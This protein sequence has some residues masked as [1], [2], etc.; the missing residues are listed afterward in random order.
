MYGKLKLSQNERNAYPVD[1]TEVSAFEKCC[2][3]GSDQ[4]LL[5]RVIHNTAEGYDIY[6][7]LSET[8]H[9]SE[10]AAVQKAGG[11]FILLENKTDLVSK[12]KVDGYLLQKNGQTVARFVYHELKSGLLVIY[13]FTSTSE[14]RSRECYNAM[15][16]YLNEKIAL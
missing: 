16:P 4:V 9:Q 15:V 1:A 14:T 2:Y 12:I 11:D 5:N 7:S 13:D 6:I 8:I 3:T 10:L